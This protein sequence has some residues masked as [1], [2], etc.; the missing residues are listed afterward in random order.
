ME[1]IESF[2]E[3]LRR[4]GT[5]NFLAVGAAVIVGWLI[6]SGFVRG[7]RRRDRKDEGPE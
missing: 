3:Y 1:T 7:L 6:I 2:V 4:I 5:H